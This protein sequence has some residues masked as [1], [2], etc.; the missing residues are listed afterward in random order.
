MNHPAKIRRRLAPT[1]LTLSSALYLAATCACTVSK[2]NSAVIFSSD[3]NQPI[4]FVGRVAYQHGS[5]AKYSWSGSGFIA[6]FA[7]TG[8]EVRLKDDR[9]EHQPVLDGVVLPKIVTRAGLE[10]YVVAKNLPLGAHRL[11][12]Y[13]RTEASFGETEFFGLKVYDG[14]VIVGAYDIARRIEVI[15]DSIS[16]GYGN[17]GKSP[18]CTFSPDTENHYL[19]YGALLA[20]EFGAVLSTVAWSG[21]GVVK[22][23]NGE[24]GEKMRD[25]YARTLPDAQT[26]V[27]N[28]VEAYDLVILNLGTNDYSTEP[29]PLA[30]EFT[31][32]YAALLAQARRNSPNAF[33]LC[34]LGPMLGPED[35]AKAEAAI[36]SAIQQRVGEG[37]R[38][39]AYHRMQ[40]QNEHPG[41]DWHPG[42]ATHAAI[43]AE[44]A[45]VV[46]SATGW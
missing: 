39:V 10:R 31:A 13:R 21:R 14:H 27:W 2:P 28:A 7:G 33:I 15:G 8:I 20:R 42:L 18:D 4:H 19:S 38:R 29:D 41:C 23:Y 30:V 25:L 45:S 43:A 6:D 16:C 46:R 26:S 37:D 34:T 9:N 17:E 40:T 44:L 12:L 5:P 24:P 1:S 32:G 35:L 36:L 3:A 22:N 11:E